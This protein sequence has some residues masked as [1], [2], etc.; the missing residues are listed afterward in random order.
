MAFVIGNKTIKRRVEFEAE[1][2]LG[3]KVP[4]SFVLVVERPDK[5]TSS[6]FSRLFAQFADVLAEGRPSEMGEAFS[7]SAFTDRVDIAEQNLS[8]FVQSKI[9]GWEDVYTI[10]KTP[11]AF[12]ADG[13][14]ALFMDRESRRAVFEDYQALVSGRRKDAEKNSGK[15]DGAGTT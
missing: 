3:E 12:N 9:T 14:K 11:L 4:C 7:A 13:L 8:S 1:G 5:P 15:P 6:E 2:D 10:D